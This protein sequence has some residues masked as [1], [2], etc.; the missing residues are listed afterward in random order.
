MST[1][2]AARGLTL[3]ELLIVIVIVGILAAGALPWYRD[4]LLRARRAECTGVLVSLANALER[5]FSASHSY[6]D[7]QGNATF[8]GGRIS[9]SCPAT[10][11]EVFY[12]IEFASLNAGSFVLRA[13]P[14]GGQ[15]QDRCGALTLDHLGVRGVVNDSGTSVTQCW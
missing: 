9:A 6:L 7:A 14:V 8:P 15:M 10:G 12:E 1:R 5:R 13:R 3:I 11:G 4:H 2:S